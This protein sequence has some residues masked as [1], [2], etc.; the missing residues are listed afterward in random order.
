MTQPIRI[1]ALAALF[2]AAALGATQAQV[3][4]TDEVLILNIQLNTVS[5]G[6]TSSARGIVQSQVQTSE[7]TSRDVIQAL[8]AV[9]GNTFSRRA[10]LTLL[11]PTNNLENWTVQIRDGSNV[12]D[13]TGFFGH[14]PGGAS[15]GSAWVVTRTGEAG[16]TSYSIDGFALQDQ[17]GFA[18]LS[19][20][21]SVSGLTITTE[22]GVINR[23]G[24]V[25]SRT[26]RIVGQVSG[27]G[28]AQGAL[29]LIQGTISAEGVGTETVTPP[30]PI[31]SV[32]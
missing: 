19:L 17:A 2:L 9:T 14:Q 12:V 7:I 23:A 31:I 15:V 29:L 1:T 26:D 11:T 5:Q 20:H 30:P 21:F 13:V 24:R 22:T 28:D 6:P 16:G 3:T 18:P 10:R 32:S 27:T 8:G 25:S 4:Q